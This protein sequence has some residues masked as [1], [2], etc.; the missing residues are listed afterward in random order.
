MT[1]RPFDITIPY[2]PAAAGVYWWERPELD[3][4]PEFDAARDGGIEQIGVDLLW[5]DFQPDRTRVA[6]GPMRQ[7]ERVLQTAWD[8]HIRVRLTFFPVRIGPMVWLPSWTLQPGTNASGRV[9]SGHHLHSMLAC[10]LFADQRMIEAEERLVRE[11]IGAFAD[12]PAITGW[13]LGRGLSSASPVGDARIF[14]QWIGALA[15]TARRAGAGQTLW[16]SLSSLDLVCRGAVAPECATAAQVTVEVVDDWKPDWATVS[17]PTWA[18]FLAAYARSIAGAPVTVGGIGGCTIRPDS[19]PGSCRMEAEV[20]EEIAAG[21]EAV[22]AS[23]GA[24]AAALSLLDY[25]DDLRRAPPYHDDPDLLT[26]GLFTT[27]AAPKATLTP[28]AAWS[29]NG[30]ALRPAM[31]LPRPDPE[32]R[33][34]AAQSVAR[35][36]YEVYTR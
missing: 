10:N 22:H 1:D 15:D 2:W 4:C 12:H 13:V 6:V 32:E 14:G 19:D 34:V 18:G 36:F 30:E 31:D 9:V 20:A 16:Y 17:R 29:T 7:L 21:L 35:E 5:N 24:G 25:D 23:G 26:A 27:H 3:V 28:W 8:R 11:V 33:H